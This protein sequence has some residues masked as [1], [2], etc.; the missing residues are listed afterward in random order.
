M[1]R[2]PRLTPFRGALGLAVGGYVAYNVFGPKAEKKDFAGAPLKKK[3][4]RFNSL[5]QRGQNPMAMKTREQHLRDLKSGEPFDIL[6]VGAGCT[7][8]GAALDAATRG[9]KTACI[10]RG[11]FSNETSSRSS[12]LI[13][14][15]F[16][17]L[18]VAFAELLSR[19]TI[20]DPVGS[21][22]KFWG[23]FGM[24]YECCQERSW[25]A[26]Q[27]EHLVQYVPQ[28]VPF[29]KL[30]QWPPY[31]DHPFYSILPVLALPAFLFYDALASFCA[32]SSYAMGPKK[33]Q[34]VFPQLSEVLYSAVYC[35]AMHNDA[36]TGTAIALTAAMKGATIANYVEMTGFVYGGPPGSTA[37]GIKCVDKLS[38]EEFV[39]RA[40]AI[41]LATGPFLDSIRRMEDPNAEKAVAAAA[42]CHIVL[43]GYFTPGNMG[44][45]ELRTSRGATMYF[46]PWL[47]HTIVGSTD[48]KCDATS[49]PAVSED[50]IQYLVNEAAT[51]LSPDIRIRRSDVLSAWQ[52]WR[53]L[54][55]D[56]QAPPGAPVSRH[57]AIG[58]DEKT[59]VTFICGGKWSTYRAMA[60]ELI[61]KVIEFK[62]PL[63][64]HASPCVTKE[65]KLMGGEGYHELL[66]VQLV[67]KY[68][69][70]E[71]VA[72][73]LVRT[74]GACAFAVCEMMKPVSKAANAINDGQRIFGSPIVPNYPYVEA[75]VEYAVKH[76]YAVTVKDMLTTRMRLAFIN[77]EAAKKA[78]PRVADLM[79]THLQWSNAEKERQIKMAQEYIGQFGGPIADKSSAK[80]RSATFTDLHEIFLSIDL[81]NS[82]YLSPNELSAAADRLGFP[83]SSKKELDEKFKEID[84]DGNGRISEAEFIE[85]WNGRNADK[86]AKKLHQQLSMTAKDEV[87]LEKLL[88]A[89][90]EETKK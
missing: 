1:S 89:H 16:K 84:I 26:G 17:Y 27:Q 54:Y 15:G 67:Q 8:S 61:N 50:E 73:H 62:S 20:F 74:Y 31:F 48:K 21:V 13:W 80:L 66:H 82:G 34:E 47:G 33:T 88:F 3:I 56:P 40:T 60:E 52:G 79:A 76:E 12:K 38:G 49:S 71:D 59:G 64:K 32:P 45:A 36:R 78:I 5:V 10:E 43:P 18:Q 72:K 44:F 4:Q 9:L 42:G 25:L 51:C 68:Q 39:V 7:G 23:E 6:I 87:A 83:F 55:R 85:W 58:H 65:I 90:E 53:P 14:G 63:L 22:K 41:V 57:H 69:I 70:S 37:T 35:E 29:K 28:A 2:L 86:F 77:S 75:E 19:K 24:V 30:F 81:D 11:D 46:L